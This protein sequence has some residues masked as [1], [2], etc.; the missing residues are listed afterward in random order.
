MLRIPAA[1][2][3]L[4]GAFPALAEPLEERPHAAIAL[5]YL[6]R[7]AAVRCPGPEVLRDQVAQRLRYDLFS[8]EAPERLT[9]TLDRINGRYR[10]TGDLRDRDG[11]V[12]YTPETI[13]DLDCADV[14]K[15]A[16][17]LLA[18]HY[19]GPRQ[20]LRAPTP[21]PPAPMPPPT[22]TPPPSPVRLHFGLA[23]ALAISIAPTAVVGPAWLVGARISN[24][25]V[26]L[27]GRALFA[28]P[29]HTSAVSLLAS[30]V[31][32]SVAACHHAAVVFGC[33]RFELGALHFA[34]AA[35]LRIEPPSP[36]L[37]GFG[38][39]AGAEWPLAKHVFLRGYADLLTLAT[40]VQLR[41]A[42]NN[43]LLWSSFLPSPSMG[44]GIGVSF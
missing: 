14:V 18:A 23:G 2:A 38:A 43:R 21:P 24:V 40:P 26:E 42:Q 12:V 22:T 8:A 11:R 16:A 15:N 6:R 44:V 31:T 39:R 7:P 1:L 29:F 37:A 28:P 19:T 25:S 36:V 30:V 27:E 41:L 9:L 33:A 32:G 13:D 4:L 20:V 5:E 35:E 3:V 34:S 10:L 17:I